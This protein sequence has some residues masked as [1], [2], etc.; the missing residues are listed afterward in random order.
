[1]AVLIR[2]ACP[3]HSSPAI[4]ILN[5]PVP[6]PHAPVLNAERQRL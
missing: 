2:N 6:R 1:M 5:A 3:S 4:S